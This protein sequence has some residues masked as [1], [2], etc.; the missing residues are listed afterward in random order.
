MPSDKPPGAGEKREDDLNAINDIAND[1]IVL[2][3][4]SIYATLG[5]V[6]ED[7]HEK[8]RNDSRPK[9]PAKV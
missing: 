1:N 2:M 9:I 8:I 7:I 3:C 6:D 5:D 4:A